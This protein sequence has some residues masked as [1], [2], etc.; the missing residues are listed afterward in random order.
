M[1]R[2][3]RF[4]I[5]QMIG[6]IALLL[7]P[8][9]AFFVVMSPVV[10]RKQDDS[11]LKQILEQP[12]H[13]Y[14]VIFAGTSH[15]LLAFQTPQ[16]FGEQGIAACNISTNSQSIPLSYHMLREMIRRHD[17]K[18]V[19]LDLFYLYV[20]GKTAYCASAHQALDPFPLSKAKAEA[21]MDLERDDMLEFFFQF[22]F[23]HSRWKE[24]KKSDY[25]APTEPAQ[26]H[27]A[28]YKARVPFPDPFTP[29]PESEIG[30]IPAI[31]LDYLKKIVEL[32]NETDTRLLLTVVP[33][34]ADVMHN[35]T[36][37]E[38]YQRL[39]NHAAQLAKQWNVDYLNTLHKLDDIGINFNTDLLDYSHVNSA[40]AEKVT[41]FYGEYLKAHYDLPDRSK[42]P[43]YA[44]W[45][46]DYAEYLDVL[47][48]NRFTEESPAL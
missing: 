11:N 25:I 32:C 14:D 28:L 18:L 34:R 41:S 6:K 48:N 42:D 33:Y 27:Y 35:D 1:R 40:G 4:S 17:P 15:S 36:P 37:G 45:H 10:T 29:V 13:T 20:P 8:L 38:Y 7:L 39:Y 21:I 5:L 3:A 30:A 44:G 26:T 47:V 46:E 24:L 12:D 22:F 43:A 19:V 9:V 16:L 2:I 23:Y 31:P